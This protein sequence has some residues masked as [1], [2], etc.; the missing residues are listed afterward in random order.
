MSAT[1]I[2]KVKT[3][4]PQEILNLE[5]ILSKR[6]SSL[7]FLYDHNDVWLAILGHLSETDRINLITAFHPDKNHL[8]T[9]AWKQQMRVSVTTIGILYLDTALLLVL[10]K[11]YKTSEYIFWLF[12]PYLNVTV[13]LFA[14]WTPFQN[15]DT[16][17][18]A[19]IYW[20]NVYPYRR[21]ELNIEEIR[22][23]IA[24][25]LHKGSICMRLTFHIVS[26]DY[27][28]LCCNVLR[29][30][31]CLQSMNA[32]PLI[33]QEV[34]LLPHPS[35]IVNLSNNDILSGIRLACCI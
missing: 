26:S 13:K 1:W 20:T 15:M 28:T 17:S 34:T 2:E 9:S 33:V 31:G 5:N 29:I 16:H 10:D 3:M 35:A 25:M 24:L 22:H 23:K 12:P 21:V 11:I 18:C 7:W 30:D 27:R 14:D 6:K 32:S 19:C 4:T 8:W